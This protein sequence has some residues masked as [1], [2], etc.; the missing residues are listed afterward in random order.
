MAIHI[1]NTLFLILSLF[2]LAFVPQIQLFLIFLVM[3][4]VEWVDKLL[5]KIYCVLL[6]LYDVIL[7]II[8]NPIIFIGL[9]TYVFSIALIIFLHLFTF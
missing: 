2:F 5:K 4:T 7:H 8:S 3:D 1:D 9:V 6:D